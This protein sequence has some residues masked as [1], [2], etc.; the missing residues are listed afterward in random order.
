MSKSINTPD[1][2]VDEGDFTFVT[3]A[4]RSNHFS[5][6][7]QDLSSREPE[8]AFGLSL[9]FHRVLQMLNGVQMTPCQR[10]AIERQMSL[11]A[12]SPVVAAT[13]AYRRAWDDFLPTEEAGGTEGGAK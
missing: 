12:W 9:R 3:E 5:S 11:L 13:R 7:V 8:I 6:L 10:M 1:C 2:F 4:V